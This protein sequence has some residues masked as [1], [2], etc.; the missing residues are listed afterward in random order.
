[1]KLTPSLP[2]LLLILTLHPLRRRQPLSMR[3]L[4]L[5]NSP[6][7]RNHLAHAPSTIPGSLILTPPAIPHGVSKL[8]QHEVAL[9][10]LIIL[11]TVMRPI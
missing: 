6:I 7:P 11:S 8:P 4:V 2:Q 3:L 5:R 1:M 9:I 10:L